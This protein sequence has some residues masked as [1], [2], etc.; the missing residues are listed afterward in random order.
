MPTK[1]FSKIFVG[2]LATDRGPEDRRGLGFMTPY[3]DNK[4]FE[5]RKGTILNWLAQNVPGRYQQTHDGRSIYVKDDAGNQRQE[6][7]DNSPMEGFLITDNIK[8][9]YWGGGNVVFRVTDPRGF[10]LEISSQNLMML[11]RNCS[12]INGSIQG[13]CIWGR[14]GATNVL[15]HESSDEYK[16]AAKAAE[17]LKKR[18]PLPVESLVVG[19]AYHLSNG[20]TAVYMG[21][22]PV[23]C[24][25]YVEEF[26]RPHGSW[27][28]G[29]Y[30]AAPGKWVVTDGPSFV[31][32]CHIWGRQPV[33]SGYWHKYLE[34]SKGSIA[35]S[36]A[37]ATKTIAEIEA[38]I[39][40]RSV[41]CQQDFKPTVEQQIWTN[42]HRT[43][44]RPVRQ[45]RELI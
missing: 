33:A 22:R 3:E 23:R 1:V 20:D 10:E 28:A 40:G 6:I 18:K 19:R 21:K 25:V 12:I 7:L 26:F 9:T 16:N 32:E 42:S 5:K 43:Y 11:L 17:T 29:Q 37:V 41:V 15:L 13:R 35:Y 36:E 8:R 45:K 34:G 38:H 2:V 30:M 14:D 24:V 4:A 31:E 44:T 27:Q 39:E